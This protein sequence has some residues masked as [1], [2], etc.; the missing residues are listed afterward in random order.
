MTTDKG[1]KTRL[2]E[3]L[4]IRLDY[5]LRIKDKRLEQRLSKLNTLNSFDFC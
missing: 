2:D 5:G 4:G 1:I 3:E